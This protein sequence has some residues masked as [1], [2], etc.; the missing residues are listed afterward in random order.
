[1][2]QTKH[3]LF[4]TGLNRNTFDSHMYKGIISATYPG[5][6]SGVRSVFT[7]QDVARAILAISLM[8]Y[9]TGRNAKAI[10]SQIGFGTD[11][12]PT[13]FVLGGGIFLN[14]NA[15]YYMEIA[16]QKMEE[17]EKSQE[18]VER[19]NGETKKEGQVSLR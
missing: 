4:A 6:R 1:M 11:N 7:I 15:N 2:F 18:D 12:C 5:I 10:V 3:I 9:T 8:D 14:I 17:Y 19:R 13:Q 16:K